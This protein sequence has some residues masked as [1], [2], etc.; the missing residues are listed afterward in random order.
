MANGIGTTS[1]GLTVS[2]VKEKNAEWMVEVKI[3]N[4]LK[5]FI[6]FNSKQI[7]IYIII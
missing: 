7:L 5:Y 4:I 3:T 2:F 6:N 1:A